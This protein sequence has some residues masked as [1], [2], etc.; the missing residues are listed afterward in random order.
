MS[1]H[2][3]LSA[4]A[5]HQPNADVDDEVVLVGSPPTTPEPASILAA[6]QHSETTNQT[7]GAVVGVAPLNTS[8]LSGSAADVNTPDVSF[9]STKKEKAVWRMIEFGVSSEQGTRKTME[10]QHKAMLSTDLVTPRD[11]SAPRLAMGIPFFGVYDGHGGQ[12]CAEFLRENLHSFILSHPRVRDDPQRAIKDGVEE[13]EKT[14]MEKCKTERIE[15]G[16]TV[17][18][19]L[20][21]D[22]LLFTG[23]VGDSEIVL[24]RNGTAKVLTVKHTLSANEGEVDRVKAC[25]GR[26]FHSRVGHPKFNPMLV[27]LAVSRAVGDAGFKLEEY[28]DGKASG[29][30]AEADTSVTELERDDEFIIIGCDGVWDVLSYQGAVDFC[31]K[32]IGDG[33]DTQHVTEQLCQEALRLGS[34][35]NVTALFVSLKCRPG[36]AGGGRPTSATQRPASAASARRGSTFEDSSSTPNAAAHHAAPKLA[37][38]QAPPS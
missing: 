3:E 26:I 28:T 5:P 34:T 8:T 24:C 4:P 30:I 16:S 19:A 31:R 35:D 29:L 37:I 18:V 15:S 20:V 1:D 17:A 13:A 33:H 36:S 9:Y 14:F 12:Q 7:G 25:G 38:P 10:D 23:N 6:H 21:V 32:L 11:R 2:N 22:E 27:S